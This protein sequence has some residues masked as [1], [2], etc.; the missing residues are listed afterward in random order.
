[1]GQGPEVVIVGAGPAGISAALRLARAGVRVLVLEG[2]EFAGAENWSG[3]V[4]HAEPLLREDVLGAR[5][6]DRAPRERRIVGRSLFIHGGDGCAGFEARAVMGN[7]YGEAWTVLRPKLDRYLASRAIACGATLLP[8]TA[9][10]GLRF[11]DGRVVGVDT[12]RGPIEAPCV[13]LA[14]GDAAGLLARAGLERPIVHYAQGIKAVFALPEA[15]IETRFGVGAG[16]GIAQEWLL[17]NGVWKGRTVPLDATGFVYTNRDS[18]SVGLVLPLDR[19]AEDSPVDH[20]QLLRRFLRLP[21]V[22]ALLEGATQ[23]AYGAKVIRSGGLGEGVVGV[24]DGLAVGGASLG[25]GLEFPYPNFMGPAAMSGVAFA[26]AV[27][28]LRTRGDYSAAALA[29]SYGGRLRRSVEYRNARFAAAWP[30][31]LHASPLIF[32]H[33]PALVGSVMAGRAAHSRACARAALSVLRDRATLASAASVPRTAAHTDAPPLSVTFLRG[34]GGRL[35][36]V[37]SD[38]PFLA[39]LAR[40]L[41]YLYGRS[42]PLLETRLAVAIPERVRTLAARALARGAWLVASGGLGFAADAAMAVATGRS[43]LKD[44]PFYRAEGAVRARLTLD[45]SPADSPMAWLAPL[46]R[47]LPERRH[48]HVPRD[49]PKAAAERLRRVCPAEVYKPGGAAGGAWATFENCIKCESCRIAVPTVDWRRTDGHGLIYELPG[50]QRFECDGSVACDLAVDS[51]ALPEDET[52]RGLVAAI[53]ARPV[54]PGP[55]FRETMRQA[56]I[57]ARPPGPERLLR[58]WERGAHGAVHDALLNRLPRVRPSARLADLETNTRRALREAAAALFPTSR[59]AAMAEAW[60]E[61]DRV[62]L[63][64]FL[65]CGQARPEDRLAALA[66]H[67]TGLGFVAMHHLLAEGRRGERLTRLTA[68]LCREPDRLS[69]WFPDV[70]ADVGQGAAPLKTAGAPRAVGLDVA[71]CVRVPAARRAPFLVDALFARYLI[72]LMEGYGEALG[73]RAE[74]HA[75][76]RVQF[77]GGYRDH[78]G[79]DAV[80]KFGA[81]KRLLAVIEY[82]LML[83]HRLRVWCDREPQAV[84]AL[85]KERF[86]VSQDGVAWCAG[87]VF[88]G[89]A[90]SEDDI[91]SHRYRDAMVL[92]QWPAGLDGRAYSAW[93]RT[94]WTGPDDA[95]AALFLRHGFFESPPPSGAPAVAGRLPIAP[96]ATASFAY[97]SGA[98]LSGEVLGATEVFVPEDF[99]ADP[100]LRRMRAQ[101]LRLVRGGF[102]DPEGKVYGRSIDERHAVPAS[103]VERLKD[104]QA[105]ATVV[106]ENLGGRGLSKA[107]Y[108]VLA[109]LLMGRVD[110]SVGLLVMA[111]TSIGTMPVLLALQKDIPRL[112]EELGD[113]P[114]GAFEDLRRAAGRLRALSERPRSAAIKKTLEAMAALVKARFL[115]PGSVLKYLARDLLGDFEALVAAARARDLDGLAARALGLQEGLARF[116]ARLAEERSRLPERIAAHERF[117]RFLAHREISAFALTEPS[118][119]SDTGAV[120][121]RARPARASLAPDVAGLWRFNAA[122][123]PR[124]LLDERRLEF[125]DAGVHYR[126]P[127]GAL[128][129]LDDSAW[130]AGQGR[131]RVVL[132]SGVM[133]DY[134]DRGVPVDSPDGPVYEYFELSGAKMWITNGSIADRYCLYA[135]APGGETGFMVERRS[136]GFAVGRDERKLGQRASPTNELALSSVRVCVSRIIG[137]EGHGQ[138]SALETLSVGRGGLVIGAANLLERLLDDYGD[139]FEAGSEVALVARSEYERVRTLGARLVG[140]MDRADLRRGDFRIE[141]ALSKFLASEGLHRVLLALEREHGPQAAAVSEPIEKWRRD[142]RILNI[143]EGTNEIQRFLVLKDLAPLFARFAQTNATQSLALDR[144]LRTFA[145]FVRPRVAEL[146]ARVGSD[147]DAQI[148]WFPVVDWVGEL[149]VWVAI[150]E[151]RLALASRGADDRFLGPLRAL[152]SACEAGVAARARAVAALFG[153]GAAYEEAVVALVHRRADRRARPVPALQDLAGS[154]IVLLRD[155]AHPD[156]ADIRLDNGDRAA[157]DQALE[158]CDREPALRLTTLVLTAGAC[159]DLVQRLR[160]AGANPLAVTTGGLADPAA[161]A[162]LVA[163]LGPALVL[164]GPQEPAFLAALAGALGAP[165]IDGVAGCAGAGRRGYIV[166]RA[167]GARVRAGYGRTLLASGRFDATGR[168]DDF[169]ITDWLVALKSPPEERRL[170]SAAVSACPAAPTTPSAPAAM[171]RPEDLVAWVFAQIGGTPVEAARVIA[172]AARLAP[173][174][175]V[176]GSGALGRSPAALA[177][178]LG[179]A[180]GAVWLAQDRGDAP[181]EGLDMPLFRLLVPAAAA[182]CASPLAEHLAPAARIVLGPEHAALAGAL[183]SRLGRPLYTDVVAAQGGDLVCE[184][185]GSVWLSPCPDHAVLVAGPRASTTGAAGR[186]GACI[187]EDLALPRVRPGGLARALY[188]HRA[189]GLAGAEVVIDVGHGGADPAFFERELM[190][191]KSRLSAMMGCEVA[192]GAT[193]RFVQESGI[194]SSEHQIGQTG[195]QVAPRLL[196]ALGV[197]GAPQHLAGIAPETQIIAINRDAEA[198]IFNTRPGA[199]PVVRC[200]GEVGVWVEALLTALAPTGTE[201]AT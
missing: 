169:A 85:L 162:T 32:E 136:E 73:V 128:A 25:L 5:E 191:L 90:Y 6:W 52:L 104:F 1:M 3:G 77:A 156:G 174:M 102:R 164:A 99:R 20:P 26:D 93:E 187:V 41:G 151:R 155:I 33:L 173:V 194:L 53:A 22:A 129:R 46:G 157:L 165:F 18:V 138:V 139:R 149:Y 23:V 47:P 125:T 9:A 108:A 159:P 103:D 68:D 116:A 135:Q 36:P 171:E 59:L 137:F 8:R 80:I 122:Q 177:H 182:S 168:S 82:A 118:A 178:S 91:L 83:A 49:L 65:R 92:A 166:R 88:G 148:L 193:R 120:T 150:V 79:S 74:A 198:P 167:H 39:S 110:P 101:V 158:A 11:R 132:D 114:E 121:T 180:V 78:D 107:E 34:A 111:S 197:S 160:A 170:A 143:Y 127:D 2:A 35:A 50:A 31:A 105:F 201:E 4:Y 69:A 15:D 58:L 89:I 124:I 7:D 13:F 172:G 113:H 153:A 200:V 40:S 163:P 66:E 176:T 62:D 179:P 154:I 140:L 147:G 192:F 188:R 98:F 86:G 17:R 30:E 161:V 72:A 75:R 21:E 195:L 87:Q 130:D 84:V 189:T 48:I 61:D 55:T 76:S 100:A 126:L 106:P 71:R 45:G 112:A 131:R 145:D 185:G 27:L 63:V 28:D 51:A 42:L 97:R 144:A 190:R 19:L 64:R 54:A 95:Q 24:Y 29:E 123:G 196:F 56:L 152:E 57:A 67:D 12:A 38:G 186:G 109:G 184:R 44:R 94:L 117:L 181:P 175:V 70:G 134:D 10:T 96:R 60:V 141:A 14:E 16:E 142:A 146:K 81:V 199:P 37:D 115:K 43:R 119:G 183:A 133:H